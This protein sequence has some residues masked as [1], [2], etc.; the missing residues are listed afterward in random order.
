MVTKMKERAINR[1]SLDYLIIDSVLR[2]TLDLHC[3]AVICR[4]SLVVEFEK[5]VY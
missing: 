2:L 3:A 5:I 4:N 1:D